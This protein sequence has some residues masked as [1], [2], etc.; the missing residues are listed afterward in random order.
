MAYAGDPASFP[1]SYS[2]FSTWG[3][4]PR[5]PRSL[6]P[7]LPSVLCLRLGHRHPGPWDLSPAGQTGRD[8]PARWPVGPRHVPSRSRGPLPRLSRSEQPGGRPSAVWQVQKHRAQPGQGPSLAQACNPSGRRPSL[9]CSRIPGEPSLLTL[10]KSVLPKTRAPA[11]HPKHWLVSRWKKG[12]GNHP[13]HLPPPSAQLRPP[14]RSPLS[15]G[16]DTHLSPTQMRERS[17]TSICACAASWV[18]LT[19]CTA[20]RAQLSLRCPQLPTLKACPAHG[21]AYPVEQLLWGQDFA[22]FI[23]PERGDQSCQ[24]C[25]GGLGPLPLRPPPPAPGCQVTLPGG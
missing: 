12:F 3:D 18:T 21:P 10:L 16:A 1:L 14:P 25:P 19:D 9:V 13:G 8:T 2:G 24:C 17:L 7:P 20:W 6:W 22:I 11:P 23:Q 15:S 5:G 4:V